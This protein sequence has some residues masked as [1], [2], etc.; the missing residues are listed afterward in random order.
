MRAGLLRFQWRTERVILFRFPGSQPV[1]FGVRDLAKL[2][3]HEFVFYWAFA[4]PL[5][6]ACSFISYWVCE[7]SDGIRVLFLVVTDLET[8]DQSTYIVSCIQTTWFFDH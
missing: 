3:S 6:D 1:S 4:R 5:T 7:K 8:K 2:E